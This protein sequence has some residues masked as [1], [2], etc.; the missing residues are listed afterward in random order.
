MSIQPDTPTTGSEA[1]AVPDRSRPR[2]VRW[3]IVLGAALWIVSLAFPVVASLVATAN[4]PRW[5]GVLDV[6]LA[7]A[8]MLVMGIV[9]L[10]SQG[11]ID[12]HAQQ[13]SYRVYRGALHLPLLLLIIF[14]LVGE[15]I[16]WD[17]LLIGLAW[18]TWVLLTILPAAFALWQPPISNPP[19]E[20][21]QD[22]SISVQP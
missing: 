15:R 16:K 22:S 21:E 1:S 11:R 5:V 6:T 20:L 17:I 19:P 10:R 8:V 18:R 12:A 7:G 9:T 13:R 14:F 3:L 2:S 4:L